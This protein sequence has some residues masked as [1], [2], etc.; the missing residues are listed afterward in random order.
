M[1]SRNRFEAFGR[2]HR[3]AEGLL[4]EGAALL[5]PAALVGVAGGLGAIGLHWIIDRLAALASAGD[6]SVAALANAPWYLRLGAPALGGLVAGAALWLLAGGARARGLPEVIRAAS[7]DGGRL[8]PREALVEAGAAAVA[9]GA[10]CSAGRE[11]PLVQLGAGAG[12]ALGRL[13]GISGEKAI[14]LLGCGAAAGF[15]ATFDAPLA[16]AVLAIEVVIGAASIRVFGPVVVASIGAAMVCRAALPGRPVLPVPGLEIA[17]PAVELPLFLLL[18]AA[19]GLVGAGFTR[20]LS[21]LEA[22]RERAPLPAWLAPALGGAAVGGV[23]VLAPEVLGAGY[24]TMGAALRGEIA[25]GALAALGLLKLLATGLTLGSGVPGGVLTPC[26]FAGACLGGAFGLLAE[27]LLPGSTGGPGAYALVG[28]GATL[29][30]AAH[31]PVTAILLL[32]ELSSD[33]AMALPLMLAGVV[34]ATLSSRAMPA[35]ILTAGLARRGVAPRRSL[36]AELMRSTKVRTILRP[37]AE[38]LPPTAPLGEVLAAALRGSLPHQYVVDAANR[39]VGTIAL[40]HVKS[41]V[42]ESGLDEALLVAADV[43]KTP[44]VAVSLE[45]SLETAMR[46]LSRMDVEALPVVDATGALAGCVT[47]HDVLVFFE[48]EILKDEALGM[49]FASGG[50]PEEAR[51]IELPEGHTVALIEVSGLLAGKTLRELDLRATAGINV[52]GI[53]VRTAE[54]IERLAPE[55]RRALE[56]GEILVA[57]GDEKAISAF[58]KAVLP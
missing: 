16:G 44:V 40:S 28:M 33:A 26:L 2:A 13:L 58:R 12:S 8:S 46:H 11:G 27:R 37:F 55:P 17:E 53:R 25:L 54:G 41:I 5:L 52:V 14:T 10:G 45:D 34:A 6:G 38:T 21:L 31:A 50:R 56:P 43:M 49:K 7:S 48:H 19:A 29:A 4:G 22:L 15:A 20:G 42:G 32:F 24:G 1:V 3:R 9:I 47:R 39:P 18:G 23:A 36:E 57:V 35:S 51:F 30:A